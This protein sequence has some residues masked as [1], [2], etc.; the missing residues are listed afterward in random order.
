MVKMDGLFKNNAYRTLELFIEQ[1]NSDFSAREIARELGLNHATILKYL[2]GLIKLGLIRKRDETLYP[3]HYANTESPEYKLYKKN[4]I[5]F[6]ITESGVVDFIQ[7]N[8]LASSI[9]LFGSCAK[10]EFT[11][12]SDIDVF[13]EAKESSLNLAKYEKKLGKKINLLFEQNINNLSKELKNNMLNGVVLYGFIK[14]G[15][16]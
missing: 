15:N 5:I 6:K 2:K 4:H 11:E 13:I 8:T 10:G 9:I 1:P 14:T 16:S 12:K 7:K 3:T